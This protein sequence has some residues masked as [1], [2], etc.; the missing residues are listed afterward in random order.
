MN[1]KEDTR[2]L[3][4]YTGGTIGMVQDAQSGELRPFAFSKLNDLM[5]ELHHLPLKLDAITTQQPIDSSNMNF[6]H[7]VELVNLIKAQYHAYNGFVILH[8]SDTMSYTASALSF[9]LV[10]LNK[11]VILTGSQL[12]LG[13][14]RTDGKENLLTAIELAAAKRPD[15]SAKISEVCVYFEY[16]LYRGNRCIKYNAEHF[17]AFKSPNYPLLAEAGV[18]ITYNDQYILAPA[19]DAVFKVNTTLS[20]A[21][22]VLPLF[23]GMNLNNCVPLSALKSVKALI[24]H[25]FG[26]GNGP[27]SD[28]FTTYLKSVIDS[29]ILIVNVSQCKAGA[30]IQGMYQTSMQF[31]ALGV[32]SAGDMTLEASITK[33]MVLLGQSQDP[34]W[35]THCFETNICG[36]RTTTYEYKP[37]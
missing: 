6:S 15:G 11:A 30:V 14:V 17:E 3:L 7:W 18:H 21:L 5:P 13:V 1:S 25:T 22:Y 27:T 20:N 10:N 32:I 12:P 37:L 19:S 16:K 23:P 8:G 24:L 26:A 28:W 4:I 34:K 36:E 2:I 31:K 29:G 35:I 33:L 9:M